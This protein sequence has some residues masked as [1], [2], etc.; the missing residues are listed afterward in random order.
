VKPRFSILTITGGALLA[1]SAAACAM[2]EPGDPGEREIGRTTE[3]EVKVVI[4]S[5]FGH[6]RI[7]RGEPEKIVVAETD[8]REPSPL[9]LSYSIRNRIGYLEITLGEASE[10]EGKHGVFRVHNIEG[11][12]WTLLFGTAIPI[13]FDIEQAVGKG[14]Y[15]MSGLQIKDFTLNNGAS[16]VVLTF[17]EPNTAVIENLSIES[18][19]SKFI[20]LRLGNANFKRFRFQGGVGSSTLDFSGALA[21]EVDVDV[22]LGLGALTVMIPEETGARVFYDEGWMS[23]I[24]YDRDF[25]KVGDNQYSSENYGAARGKMNIRIEAGLGSVKLRRP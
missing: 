13:S 9:R 20:G 11:G 22:E 2:A 24:D 15:D 7:A 6:V 18:G 25:T 8:E 16:D 3:R 5:T 12:T 14:E 1:L 17:N 10:G 21:R 4:S 23:R 19:V